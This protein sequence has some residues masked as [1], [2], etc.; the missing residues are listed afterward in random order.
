VTYR[1]VVTARAPADAIAAF[2]WLAERSP[3]AAARWYDGLEKVI[4]TLKRLPERH[5]VAEEESRQ[6]G[7]TLRQMLYG[8][9]RGIYRIL[10]SIE[11]DTV[12]LHCVRHSAE[13]PIQE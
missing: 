2:G 1:V 4:S 13:G 10:F 11:G 3:D 9:R 5:P 7:T 6:L 8:R 12:T